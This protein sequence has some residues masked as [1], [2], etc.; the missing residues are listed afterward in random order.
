LVIGALVYWVVGEICCHLLVFIKVFVNLSSLYGFSSLVGLTP[1]RYSQLQ[2]PRLSLGLLGSRYWRKYPKVT[3]GLI[4]SPFWKQHCRGR[5]WHGQ[6]LCR[7]ETP[8]GIRLPS[9]IADEV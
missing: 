2:A 6:V 1:E 9:F 3:V 5:P 7:P 8:L 4:G